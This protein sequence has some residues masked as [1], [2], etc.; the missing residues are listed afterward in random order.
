[1]KALRIVWFILPVVTLIIIIN[2]CNLNC[3]GIKTVESKSL[4]SIVDYGAVGDGVTMNTKSIQ[5]AIDECAKA[6]GGIV[7]FP[8]GKFLTGTIVLKNNVELQLLRNAILLGSTNQKDYPSQPLP[9]YRALRDD[10][11]FNA[12]IYAEGVNRIAIT[13]GGT[14]DAQGQLQR[15]IDDISEGAKDDRPKNLMFVSCTNIVVRDI[16]MKSSGFWNQHYLNCEDMLLDNI[17]VYN[18]SNHNNDAVDI[19]GCRRVMISNC[20]FDA[21]DDALTFKSTGK[22]LCEDIT[23]TNCILSSF[24][25]AIKAGTESTGG[26]KNITISN[27]VVKPSRH[28]GK[29]IYDD[30]EPDS[31]YSAISLIVVDGGTMEGINI[32]DIVVEGTQAPIYIRLGNR[33]RKHT[34]DAP[35]PPVGI[36][37][38]I[39][40]SNVVCYG[41]GV[42]TSSIEGLEGHPIQNISLNNIQLLS[43]GGVSEGEFSYEVEEN[44]KG[45]PEPHF[46]PLPACGLFLRHVDGITINNMI[47]GIENQDNRVPIWVEDVTNLLISDSRVSG[48]FTAGSF[49]KG[50]KLTQYKI[51]KPLGWNGKG[52][53]VQ[54]NK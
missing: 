33:A 34:A 39:S 27:C 36:V 1:M 17:N 6:G 9:K 43:V 54:V 5:K 28:S 35:V 50:K 12:L 13:G 32:S 19:D 44:D 4:F 49:V 31:G 29:R 7:V 48:V 53:L 21:V 14:I 20:N 15:T 47:I 40:I 37:K 25:N 3:S 46:K 11:G 51:E 18:H 26:F 45:Y 16:T 38:N 30:N 10:G 8:K 24:T 23:V 42:W 52:N 41:A 2:G 22:A